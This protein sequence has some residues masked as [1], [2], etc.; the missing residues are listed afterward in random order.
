MFEAAILDEIRAR[1]PVSEIVGRRVKLTRA[2]REWKGLSPFNKERSPSF[3]V[4]DQKQ[5]WHDFSS[6][7]HGD[8]FRFLME[9]EGRTFP[10]AV[11]EIAALAGV[12]LPETY[13]STVTTAAPAPVPVATAQFEEAEADYAREVAERLRKARG[14]WLRSLPAAGSVV[15]TYLR[16]RGY[17]GPIPAT[18]RYLPRNGAWPP[19]LIAAYGMATEVEPGRLA[20]ADDAVV[21]VH[22][23]KLKP[24]GSDR[25]REDG[26]KITIG[27]SIVAPIVLAPPND[28]LGL[29]IAEGIED[30]LI[31]H[32]ATGLGSWAAGGAT[33]LPKLADAIPDYIEAVTI[34]VD[35]NEAGRVNANELAN[36]IQRLRFGR[37]EVL[38]TPTGADP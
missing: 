24:D 13:R 22:L 31:A 35:D 14:L 9:A 33:K 12:S 15:E 23:I 27:K 20:I 32:Q 26:A 34:P 10:E 18:V 7:K 11:E 5:F 19:A 28:L 25:L 4:N 29:C 21:G 16:A 3:F 8:V 30:A 2:G 1:V 36:R 38:M 37:T 6:S 17:H